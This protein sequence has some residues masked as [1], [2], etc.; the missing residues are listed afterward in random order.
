MYLSAPGANY[1]AYA[2]QNFAR[3]DA[4]LAAYRTEFTGA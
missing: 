1:D 2:K 4:A 3:F